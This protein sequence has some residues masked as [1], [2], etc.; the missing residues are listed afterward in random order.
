MSPQS[1][2]VFTLNNLRSLSPSQGGEVT[3]CFPVYPKEAQQHCP[4]CFG[5]RQSSSAP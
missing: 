4:H 5:L 3:F 1:L 2:L